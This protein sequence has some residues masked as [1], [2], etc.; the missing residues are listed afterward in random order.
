MI[1]LHH[2]AKKEPNRNSSKIPPTPLCKGGQWG[3]YRQYM[4]FLLLLLINMLLFVW[5]ESPDK[6]IDYRLWPIFWDSYLLKRPR[7]EIFF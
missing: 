5:H 7:P 4:G 3:I 1:I 6:D 2:P